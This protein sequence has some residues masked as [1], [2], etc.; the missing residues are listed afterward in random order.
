MNFVQQ[1]NKKKYYIFISQQPRGSMMVGIPPHF[2]SGSSFKYVIVLK[3]SK[4]GNLL[5]HKDGIA[6]G[7]ILRAQAWCCRFF[8]SSIDNGEQT[9]VNFNEA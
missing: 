6:C 3:D 7:L 5:K 9:E 4:N 1:K 2:G 8:L